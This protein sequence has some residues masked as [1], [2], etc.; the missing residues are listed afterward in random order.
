MSR[1]SPSFSPHPRAL[2]LIELLISLAITA[3]VAGIIAIL[4][5]ATA[6]GTNSQQ[7]GRRALVKMQSIKA[8]LGDTLANARCILAIGPNYVVYWTGD[9]PG[10]VTPVNGA[11]NLSELRLLE[12]DT[13]TGN[14]NLYAVQWPANCSTNT[15]LSTD[16]TYAANT[17][18]YAACQTAKT[19]GGGYFS[20]TLIAT[21]V[22]SLAAVLDA[23]LCTQARMISVVINFNDTITTRQVLVSACLANQAAPL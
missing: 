12:L 21:N 16:Q 2:T 20:P 19:G 11:V 15:I 13:T 23:S 6:T 18:W 5:N 3:V 22:T 10:A 8:Q 17:T 7:D 14:L 9:I 4:I 1:R